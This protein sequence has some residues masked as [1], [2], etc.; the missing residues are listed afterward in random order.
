[1]ESFKEND[2]ALYVI[3]E[4]YR[5]SNKPYFATVNLKGGG[6]AD[7]AAQAVL[8]T[9]DWDM[10]WNLQVEPQILQQLEDDGG[11]GKVYASPPTNVE[12]IMFNFSDPNVEEDG[13]RSNVNVP[14]PFLTDINVRKAIALATDGQTIADQFYLG[15]ELEPGGRNYLTGIAE[16][17]SP[18]TESTFDLEAAT[19]LLEENGWVMEGDVRAKDGVE[20]KLTYYTSINAVRQ[21]TQAVNKKNWEDVGFKV[22]LGQ[23]DSGV[24]FDSAPGNEQTYGH[25]YRDIQMYT[26]GPVSPFPSSYM[27]DYYSGDPTNVSQKS[28]E[29]SGNNNQR[30]INEE[31]NG[32]YDELVATTDAERAAELFIQMNDIVINEYVTV[33]EVSRASEK[34]AYSNL[35]VAE[36][37]TASGWEPLY[38]NI[39]NW[40]AIDQ[41]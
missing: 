31:Y 16:Y 25:N 3:N 21:K 33:P 19:Q 9:G 35:L 32:L 6:S 13:Q 40:T 39:A 20:L 18:N 10:A 26:N 22:Q 8:Q 41:S 27:Q 14:H 12:R 23:V 38:W 34:Y 29:W 7:S 15:G 28:N 5:E 36:N 17:E 1:M 37:V 30:Y 24:F 11:M 2:Q 4:N